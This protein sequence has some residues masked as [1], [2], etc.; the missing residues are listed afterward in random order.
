MGRKR[1]ATNRGLSDDEVRAIYARHQ[2]LERAGVE[3]GVSARTMQRYMKRLGVKLTVGRR[4][5]LDGV[6]AVDN[7]AIASRGARNLPDLRGERIVL[8]DV[9]GVATPTMAIGAYVIKV[10]RRDPDRVRI[11]ATLL[12]GR[13]VS[14]TTSIAAIKDALVAG[15]TPGAPSD[16]LGPR[17]RG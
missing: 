9:D 7:L 13:E 1:I 3:V 17:S 8:R 14:I 2:S 11:L 16:P 15:D 4:P 12:N 5:L 6:P 10:S